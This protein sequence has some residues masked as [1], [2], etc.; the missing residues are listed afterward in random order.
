MHFFANVFILRYVLAVSEIVLTIGRIAMAGVS[1]L[2]HAG[3]LFSCLGMKVLAVLNAPDADA[4]C[5]SE[6]MTAS[7]IVA[8]C[9]GV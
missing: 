9:R 3:I 1:N 7:L 4:D 6:F 2:H 5:I 8:L